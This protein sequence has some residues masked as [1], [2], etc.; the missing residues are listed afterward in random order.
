MKS[1][2]RPAYGIPNRGQMIRNWPLAAKP[3]NASYSVGSNPASPLVKW[4]VILGAGLLTI[5]AV[6]LARK[7][8]IAGATM[9][10]DKLQISELIKKY[11]ST[12]VT[13]IPPE[14]APAS[15]VKIYPLANATTKGILDSTPFGEL[16]GWT[17]SGYYTFPADT[18]S[19]NQVHSIASSAA[20][21]VAMTKDAAT[22]VAAKYGIKD[23]RF[24]VAQAGHE[25]NWGKNAIGTANIFGHVASEKWTSN[26]S[27]KYSYETTHEWVKRSDG[28]TV[29][30][31]TV[32][33]FRLYA[34]MDEA[35]E[36][37]I[38]VL[39]GHKEWAGL[40]T[41]D[42]IEEYATALT[43]KPAYATDPDYV[44]YLKSA[45]NTVKLY[46]S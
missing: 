3:R 2:K 38:A 37:H 34:T 8:V 32:R 42:T 11:F 35:F 46:W 1:Y 6:L 22:R 30:I 36:A 28:T 27:H 20:E 45:Y 23:P 18:A 16:A 21:F 9:V 41:A 39:K 40:F 4:S 44:S 25:G 7:P 24:L 33:P 43:N 29:K 17:S 19:V 15:L 10:I 31:P 26:P 5:A 12:P 14:D 13:Q